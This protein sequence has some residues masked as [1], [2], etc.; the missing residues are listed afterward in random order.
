LQ[1][2][3]PTVTVR[4]FFLSEA[5]TNDQEEVTFSAGLGWGAGSLLFAS[6]LPSP[7]LLVSPSRLVVGM[8][9]DFPRLSVT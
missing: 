3:S 5:A 8:V 7:S 2:Q 9:E 4:L 1:T 6:L